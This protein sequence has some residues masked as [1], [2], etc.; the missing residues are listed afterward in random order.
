[1]KRKVRRVE[2]DVDEENR[3]KEKIEIF[4]EKVLG[5]KVSEE[6]LNQRREELE[7]QRDLY[8][9]GVI[10]SLKW[11]SA[12][13]VGAILWIGN[14]ITSIPGYTGIIAIEGLFFLVMSL[15]LA[16]IAANKI[17]AA[18]AQYWK[19]ANQA[20]AHCVT[21]FEK[22]RDPSLFD[23]KDIYETVLNSLKELEKVKPYLEPDRFVCWIEWHRN[24]LLTGL[25]FY[26]I[27]QVFLS[28]IS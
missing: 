8:L 17:L 3:K 19:M 23:E 9:Q 4:M 22:E 15:F 25:I 13:V 21:F 2:I 6:N 26:F 7:E 27:S 28:V 11:T 24:F 14:I 20:F 18:R 5:A 10:D 1:M 12:I 16:I